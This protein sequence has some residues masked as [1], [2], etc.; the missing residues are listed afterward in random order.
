MATSGAASGRLAAPV[1]APG[2]VERGLEVEERA[3]VVA[4]AVVARRQARAADVGAV[5]EEV[6]PAAGAG[7]RRRWCRDRGRRRRRRRSCP[8]PCP[9]PR[10][11]RRAAR[12]RWRRRA[13]RRRRGPRPRSAPGSRRRG[14]CCP[15]S[16][17]PGPSSPGPAPWGRRSDLRR[18]RTPR[19][20]RGTRRASD[21]S[22]FS[23]L[24]MAFPNRMMVPA[25]FV[26]EA[27]YRRRTTSCQ[28]VLIQ[29][30][31]DTAGFAG[32]P[33]RRRSAPPRCTAHFAVPRD[34]ACAIATIIRPTT[35]FACSFLS[36]RRDLP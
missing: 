36:V 22:S 9:P 19:P 10:R 21:A 13:R 4:A 35:D 17:R 16:P 18:G 20:R 30:G 2:E 32:A 26:R 29:R 5:D 25:A 27:C 7:R 12:R 23:Q 14:W 24:L 3:A 8:R 6:E 34:V 1:W 28:P 11:R 31:G 15:A 33:H